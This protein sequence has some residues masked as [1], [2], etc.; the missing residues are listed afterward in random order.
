MISKERLVTGLVV[1]GLPLFI[2]GLVLRPSVKRM[3]ALHARIRQAE[4]EARNVKIFTPVSREERAFLE[5]PGAPWRL[6]MPEVEGD[7]ARLA[8]VNRVVSAVDA[9][10][11]EH[12][13]EVASMRARW[14][15]V[16]ADFTLPDP[17]LSEA[18][19]A[20]PVSDAPEKEVAAWVLEVEL[21]GKTEALF[22]ALA[23]VADVQPLL[24]PVGLRWE[25]GQ[26]K[27]GGGHRQFLFL[28]N[29]YLHN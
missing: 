14:D 1:A 6:R 3:E 2:Y 27:E 24:E 13:V 17:T 9:S 15:P 19:P 29:F 7:G 25:A 28:R 16:T 11:K 21:P 12:G 20:P 10:L 4:E 5:D 26:A 18:R 22:K 8:Q 23:A